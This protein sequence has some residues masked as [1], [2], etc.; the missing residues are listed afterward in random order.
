M[1]STFH[2]STGS[3]V[4]VAHIVL[5]TDLA[6]HSPPVG[7]LR[8]RFREVLFQCTA[9]C[10]DATQSAMRQ[11]RGAGAYPTRVQSAL[12][13]SRL[14]VDE[15]Q[16]GCRDDSKA[17]YTFRCCGSLCPLRGL[18][19]SRFICLLDPRYPSHA[20]LLSILTEQRSSWGHLRSLSMPPSR[21]VNACGRRGRGR[22]RCA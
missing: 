2:S 5:P 16:G 3:E 17:L 20:E 4:V 18:H 19:G 14:R 13:L 8:G 10:P 7:C 11:W 6:I 1:N 15:Q 9:V 21:V 22:G 12:R